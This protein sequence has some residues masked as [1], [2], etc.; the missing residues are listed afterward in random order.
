MIPVRYSRGAT[1]KD[2][3]PAQR[4]AATFDEFADAVLNDRAAA[5]G[6]AYVCAPMAKGT[7]RDP[8]KYLGEATWRQKHLA[9]PRAFLPFD[10]D[11]F[12]TP[13][14]FAELL[15]WLERFKGFAYT[16]ASHK[17]EAPRCRVVL[18]Q[19]REPE[20]GR[21]LGRAIQTMVERD[22]GAGRVKFDESVYRAEQPLF[23]PLHGA[24]AFR[25]EGTPVDVDAVLAETSGVLAKDRDSRPATTPAK[26]EA[27]IAAVDPVVEKLHSLGL[28]KSDQGNGKYAV[29]CPFRD[30]HTGE[31]AETS[32]VYLLPRFNGVQY[33]KFHCLHV[34]CE[35]R[36]QEDYIEALGLK[37]HEVWAAHR[38]ERK[39]EVCTYAGGHF[40]VSAQGVFFIGKDKEGVEKPPMRICSP[41]FIL[42]KT[43]DTKG[44]EWGRLLKWQ[45]SD[46]NLHQWAMPMEMLQGDGADVR[47]E[48]ARYGLHITP[49]RQGRELFMAYIQTWPVEARA[50]CVDRLGWNGAIFVTPA[51]AVGAN[52]ESVV[53]QNTGAI[54]P[55]LSTAGTLEDWKN[56]VAALAAGNSRLVFALSVAFAGTL[57][58]LAGEDS[59]G[60]HFRGASFFFRQKHGAES[61][62]FR[63]GQSVRVSEDVASNHERAGRA[64][65]HP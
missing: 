36:N 11:G 2:N 14:A 10:L 24:E 33:G 58:E 62:R 22:L 16:T 27:A 18:A 65:C 15:Q 38:G 46:G 54:E 51:L 30:E 26:R 19:S 31:S 25:F 42:A 37:P 45:D 63:V 5:K 28:F 64:G 44:C 7:H 43:R 52:D 13:E 55:A 32:T 41:L 35:G 20:E 17:P 4:K 49:S 56:S 6:K 8:K 23:T 21:R 9:Q 50:Q 1:V 60:F 40:K 61:R 53:F 48:L 59:G 34:H 57:A 3:K 29:H 47:R 39:P 12:D